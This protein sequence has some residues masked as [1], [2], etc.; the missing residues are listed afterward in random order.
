MNDGIINRKSKFSLKKNT[1]FFYC[2]KEYSEQNINNQ[3]K[4]L[5]I[6]YIIS[7]DKVIFDGNVVTW[8]YNDV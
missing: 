8:N 2:E 3:E 6:V 5:L 1:L 7:P 4:I